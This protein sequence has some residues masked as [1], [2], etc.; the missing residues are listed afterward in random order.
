MAFGKWKDLSIWGQER[1]Y[2]L[3]NNFEKNNNLV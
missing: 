3:Q 1:K 2:I